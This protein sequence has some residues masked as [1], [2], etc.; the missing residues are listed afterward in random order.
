MDNRKFDEW[1]AA[2]KPLKGEILGDAY[3]EA[4]RGMSFTELEAY[5]Y[6][7]S[8]ER[9]TRSLSLRPQDRILDIGPY[10]GGWAS[11]LDMYFD[12]RLLIDLIGLGMSGEFK[13]RLASPR[14]R[15]IDFDVDSE[16]PLCRNPGREIPLEASCYRVVSLLETIEHLFNPLPLLRRIGQALAPDGRLLLTTDNP[17]WFGFA[18]QSL[19]GKRSPW[20]PV[21]ESHLFNHSDWRAHVRLY[22]LND[23][24]FMLERTGMRVVDSCYFNDHFGLYALKE[25]KLKFRPGLKAL[26]GKLPSLFL[27]RR[28][29]ANRI[30]VLA[31]RDGGAESI[32]A[33]IPNANAPAL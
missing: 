3:P 9:L 1:L 21:Q 25:G 11:L 20:G 12:Q 6:R 32:S 17:A 8:L 7:L 13:E 28:L 27:P 18:Y 22:D 23:L 29:W 26:R 16:N 10:P 24:A 30:L 2:Y 15:F 19:R 5:R 14:F 4:V 31:A 33:E